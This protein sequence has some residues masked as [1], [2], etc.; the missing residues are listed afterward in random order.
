MT[1][2]INWLI[3]VLQFKTFK[4]AS[5]RLNHTLKRSAINLKRDKGRNSIDREK[6]R[7]IHLVKFYRKILN[8][9]KL[10]DK[11]TNS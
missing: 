4:M 5:L 8:S 2:R 6:F 10:L 11:Q 1:W 7:C 3:I 9:M